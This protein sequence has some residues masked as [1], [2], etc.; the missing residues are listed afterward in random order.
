MGFVI[1]VIIA[2][3]IGVCI[4]A[5]IADQNNWTKF[6]AAHHCQLVAQTDGNWIYGTSGHSYYQNGTK[7]FKCDNGVTYT[8]QD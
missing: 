3:I 6:S 1:G 2:V 7:T 5:G 4:W 8:R